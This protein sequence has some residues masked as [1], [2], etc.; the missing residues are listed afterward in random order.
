MWGVDSEAL[1]APVD[2]ENVNETTSKRDAWIRQRAQPLF[3]QKQSMK[4]EPLPSPKSSKKS[5]PMVTRGFV[6]A[7]SPVDLEILNDN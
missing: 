4:T 5:I 1:V 3:T 2:S 6:N 7:T